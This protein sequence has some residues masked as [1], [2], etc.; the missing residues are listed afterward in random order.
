MLPLARRAKREHSE[1]GTTKRSLDAAVLGCYDARHQQQV[2]PV[3][4]FAQSPVL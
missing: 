1:N 2:W 4:G 3:G